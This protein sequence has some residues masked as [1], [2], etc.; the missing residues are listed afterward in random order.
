[1][2]LPFDSSFTAKPVQRA[3]VSSTSWPDPDGPARQN[4]FNG[5]IELIRSRPVRVPCKGRPYNIS[6]H[7]CIS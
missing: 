5:I 7:F 1:M 6:P 4:I 3:F 2:E